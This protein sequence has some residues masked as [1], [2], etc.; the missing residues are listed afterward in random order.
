[1]HGIYPGYM[2]KGYIIMLSIAQS[3]STFRCYRPLLEG[4]FLT[5]LFRFKL[6][7]SLIKKKKKVFNSTINLATCLLHGNNQMLPSNNKFIR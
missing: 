2:D 3:N 5:W 7:I 6:I 4:F 1:M